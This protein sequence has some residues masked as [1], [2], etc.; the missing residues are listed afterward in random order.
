MK[1]EGIFARKLLKG[2]DLLFLN[3]YERDLFFCCGLYAEGANSGMAA[4]I[5]AL[6]KEV[7]LRQYKKCEGWS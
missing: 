4:G 5:T 2:V 7:R 6:M 3:S 1:C